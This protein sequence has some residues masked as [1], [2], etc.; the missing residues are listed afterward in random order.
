M[1][2]RILRLEAR[3][4]N[5]GPYATRLLCDPAFMKSELGKDRT[6]PKRA[7]LGAEFWSALEQWNALNPPSRDAR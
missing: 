1:A 7:A 4:L 5:I 6:Q 3:N 2:R